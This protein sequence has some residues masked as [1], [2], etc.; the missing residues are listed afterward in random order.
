MNSSVPIL[1]SSRQMSYDGVQRVESRGLNLPWLGLGP[2][3]IRVFQTSWT[4]DHGVFSNVEDR[5]GSLLNQEPFR[6][7]QSEVAVLSDMYVQIARRDITK[8][9]A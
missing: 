3:P 2:G 1:V 5:V 9:T 4:S 6:V 8:A 7:A